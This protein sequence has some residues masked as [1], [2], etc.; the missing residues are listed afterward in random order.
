ML[1][2]SDI[3]GISSCIVGI[4]TNNMS[5]IGG[6]SSCILGSSSG[7]TYTAAIPGYGGL[8]VVESSQETIGLN[9]VGILNS[10]N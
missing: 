2:N 6:I 7:N 8:T 10:N 5:D 3:G 4:N 1:L 9:P